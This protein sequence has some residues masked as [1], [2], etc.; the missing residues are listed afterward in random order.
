MI[1]THPAPKIIFSWFELSCSV[2]VNKCFLTKF[3][4]NVSQVP[5]DQVKENSL[6]A[7]EL[8]I[9]SLT[10]F[11][12]SIGLPMYTE[13]IQMKGHNTIESLANL[14]IKDIQIVTK[15]DRK[16]LKRIVHALEWVQTRLNSPSRKAK[17]SPVKDKV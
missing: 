2:H 10:E 14:S 4:I 15:A 13:A 16:H 6:A 5:A 12:T 17:T 3:S 7:S 11:F 8:K 9:G 1:S